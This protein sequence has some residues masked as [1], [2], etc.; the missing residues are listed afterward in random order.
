MVKNYI[1]NSPKLKTL[2]VLK[3]K[4][5]LAQMN[6]TIAMIQQLKRTQLNNQNIYQLCLL[7][8][9]RLFG[10]CVSLARQAKVMVLTKQKFH[11]RVQ[12]FIRDQQLW[13]NVSL[14]NG[15]HFSQEHVFHSSPLVYG[16]KQHSLHHHNVTQFNF[17][18]CSKWLKLLQACYHH[19]V[20]YGLYRGQAKKEIW[21]FRITKVP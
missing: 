12:K 6:N 21:F 20:F 10:T 8:F 4:G 3:Q 11:K 19:K 16:Y 14:I 13:Q 18:F 15:N 17:D 7:L 1:I 5:N 9:E 2:L